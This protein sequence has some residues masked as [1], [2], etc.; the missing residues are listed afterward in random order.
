MI[1]ITLKLWSQDH[2]WKGCFKG[3]CFKTITLALPDKFVKYLL[4]DSVIVDRNDSDEEE[5]ECLR[6]SE[7]TEFLFEVSKSIE[8]LGGAV[9]PRLNWSC[10]K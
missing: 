6:S 2:V 4:M 1:N 5:Q 9:I 3:K 7:V 8:L 10:P